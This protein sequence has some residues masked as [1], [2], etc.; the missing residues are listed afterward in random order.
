MLNTY[1]SMVVFSPNFSEVD[2]KKEN[3]KIHTFLK[4]NGGE[5]VETEELGKKRLAYE[6]N[7]FAEGYY[8][9]NYYKFAK[10]KVTELENYFKLNENII[11]FNILVKE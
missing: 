8:F 3:E 11:R 5:I 1:E 4:N 6:I 10:D 2:V 9:V 7:K